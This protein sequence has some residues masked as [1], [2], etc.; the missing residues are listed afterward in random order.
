MKRNLSFLIT[1]IFISFINAQQEP[2]HLVDARIYGTASGEDRIDKVVKDGANNVYTLSL[3]LT[4]EKA[5]EWGVDHH[6]GFDQMLTKFDSNKNILWQKS[7]GGDNSELLGDIYLLPDGNVLLFFQSYSGPSGNRTAPYNGYNGDTDVWIVKVDGEDGSILQQ[8]SIVADKTQLHIDC[9]IS[10]SGEIVI[11]GVTFDSGSNEFDI[12]EP[13]I[14]VDNE[15]HTGDAWI[16]ILDDNLNIVQ[17]KRLVAGFAASGGQAHAQLG[18]L[19]LE[20]DYIYVAVTSTG[21]AGGYKSEDAF[22]NSNGD[23]SQDGWILKLDWDFNKIWDRTI[24]GSGSDRVVDMVKTKDD[25][26]IV[27]FSS[28]STTSGN[29]LS[30]RIGNSYH[31]W[32][33][34]MDEDGGVITE[35]SYGNAYEMY[36]ETRLGRLGDERFVFGGFVTPDNSFDFYNVSFFGGLYDS[37]LMVFD[38]DLEMVALEA[39]G[40]PGDDI[41]HSLHVADGVIT[42]GGQIKYDGT[43]QYHPT[44]TGSVGVYNMWLLE[45]SSTLSLNEE[46]M[47]EFSVYPNPAR[48]ILNVKDEKQV[49]NHLEVYDLLGKK[50]YTQECKSTEIH[51]IDVE[52]METGIY[53]L[54]MKLKDGSEV[55]KKFVV[56]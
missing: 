45:F 55:T 49:V 29:R 54:T 42:T 51:F 12:N 2:F 35:K 4:I 52:S 40:T 47:F 14:D 16:A 15:N 48:K 19:I 27:L 24:G 38:D 10:E 43:N 28:N 44:L 39:F 41:L 9:K 56:E 8:R 25:D 11:L 23:V 36:V 34:K 22:T 21:I 46:A 53:L 13:P 32:L 17:Q 18:S 7:Y 31:T 5:I 26:L 3:I 33:V 1:L 20:E 30:P 50:L 37:Y 6:G